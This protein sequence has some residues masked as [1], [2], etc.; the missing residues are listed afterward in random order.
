MAVWSFL[1]EN[2]RASPLALPLANFV[3]AINNSS[4]AKMGGFA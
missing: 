4:A 2:L 3:T 1:G